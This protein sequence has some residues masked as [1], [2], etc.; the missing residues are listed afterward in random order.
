MHDHHGFIDGLMLI[1]ALLG[2]AIVAVS[3]S[4]RIRL[5]PMIGYLIAGLVIGP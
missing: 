3:I 4:E 2:A 1:I 5:S